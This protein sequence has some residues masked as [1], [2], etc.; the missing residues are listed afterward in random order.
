MAP[1]AIFRGVIGN[2]T[3]LSLAIVAGWHIQIAFGIFSISTFTFLKFRVYVVKNRMSSKLS[4]LQ[5]V[6]GIGGSHRWCQLVVGWCFFS[7][8][9]SHHI[10]QTFF[11][12]GMFPVFCDFFILG[13]TIYLVICLRFRTPYFPLLWLWL[14]SPS[15]CM[16]MYV[17]MYVWIYICIHDMCI[18]CVCMYISIRYQFHRITPKRK[19]EATEG[20][21]GG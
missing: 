15:I 7:L 6:L 4:D 14:Y 17:C 16:C 20:L 1:V 9:R 8:R 3:K 21:I 19:Q 11:G 10:D 13:Y 12:I 18:L 5:I 2:P